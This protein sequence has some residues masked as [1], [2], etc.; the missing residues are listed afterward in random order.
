VFRLQHPSP[1]AERLVAGNGWG[2]KAERQ[3]RDGSRPPVL[4]ARASRHSSLSR[5]SPNLVRRP[6]P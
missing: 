6:A 1:T 2:L 3:P 4:S 5:D